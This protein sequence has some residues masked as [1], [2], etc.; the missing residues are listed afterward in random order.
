MRGTQAGWIVVSLFAQLGTGARAMPQAEADRVGIFQGQSDVGSVVPPGTAAYDAPADRYALTSAGANTWYHVDGFHYLWTKTSGDWTLTAKITFAPPAYRHEPNPHR[1]GILMFRQSLDAG[2]AYAALAVHGSGM[3]ALQ[4]RRERGANTEDIEINTDQAETVR[5]EKRGDVFTVFLSRNDE[6]FHQVGASAQIRLKSPFY[7]GLGALSHDVSTTDQVY[8][9]HVALQRPGIANNTTRP[10]LYSTIQTIQVEDQY[11][12]AAVIRSVPAF[13]Q[14]VNWTAGG[15]A[16]YVDEEGHLERIDYLDPPAGAA[17]QPVAVGKLVDCSS[18]FGLSPDGKWLAVSCS[19]IKQG[20]RQIYLL[21]GGGGDAPRALTHGADSSYFHAWS[22]DSGIVA[23]TRGS[24]SKA[25]IFTIPATGGAESRLT[26][27]TINDG[28]D[29]SPDGKYLA[30]LSQPGNAGTGVGDAALRIMASGDGLIRT[31]VNFQGDRGSFAMY[32]WGDLN[33]LAF[34]SYQGLDTAAAFAADQLRPPIT[35]VSHIA[36]YAADPVASER[37]Y[38]HDLGALKAEDAENAHGVRHHFFSTQYVEVLPLP[39]DRPSINRLDHVAFAT[40][41]A[42]S[43]RAYL[44]A[45]GI[46][47]PHQV[48]RGSDGSEWFDVKDPE[49]NLIQFEQ[50]SAHPP[51]VPF[52]ALSTHLIHVGFIIHGRG[53]EDGFFRSA[54][55]FKPYWFG[56]MRDDAPTWISLQVPDGSDWLEYMIVGT[57]GGRGIPADMNPADLGILNHFSLGVANIEATYTLLWNGDRLAGQ[58]NVPKIGR[59]AKWQLNLLDPD[60]TR[61]EIM[62]LH[63][64]GKPCCSPFTAADPSR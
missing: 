43:L 37:F 53:R 57:P 30:F 14:S 49:G 21:P 2:S 48:M 13:M 5:V 58:T 61:A 25:D 10:V 54:L 11:R 35:G 23:F 63:A 6:S 1:K 4:F 17:P 42:E 36:I 15:K 29:F 46:T 38:V 60:G 3:P 28:P 12:R 31:L 16:L 64:I 8:F 51:A 27:D 18:N 40:T 41:N 34:V 56:G 33:H 50:A 9:S 39:R 47:V 32:S 52:N 59:D 44:A 19:E 45:K 7:V 22:A 55:G 20:K 24:A 26:Q 62:E